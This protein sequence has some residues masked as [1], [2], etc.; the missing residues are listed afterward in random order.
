MQ[1]TGSAV[2]T[3][4]TATS[5]Q[6]QRAPDASV[7]KADVHPP[8]L[9][10]GEDAD[11]EPIS[12]WVTNDGTGFSA[13]K[14]HGVTIASGDDLLRWETEEVV[15]HS[16]FSCGFRDAPDTLPTGVRAALFSLAD[17]SAKVV[18]TPERRAAASHQDH[19]E[20]VRLTGSLGPSLFVRR[21][22]Y[23]YDCGAHGRVESAFSL[24]DAHTGKRSNLYRRPD[25]APGQSER[26]RAWQQLQNEMLFTARP[27]DLAL[28]A[29][30]PSFRDGAVV[31]V[32]QW[33]AETCY[34]CGDNRWNSYTV[35]TEVDA[36][37]W[38]TSL[39]EIDGEHAR[40]LCWVEE[41]HPD[42]T[43]RG[44]SFPAPG[45]HDLFLDISMGC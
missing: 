42:I 4:S 6:S 1:N 21:D 15:L 38:P 36:P 28:T 2:A 22:I 13:S 41:A 45:A 10:W 44:I 32:N 29:H 39:A 30:R 31:L 24:I 16:E 14:R 12:L 40:A 8:V 37:Q 27:G 23:S 17:R 35:S 26:L 7:S 43:L 34:A 5:G 33:T 19:V 20:E 25:D 9:L 3:G 18:V 11:G